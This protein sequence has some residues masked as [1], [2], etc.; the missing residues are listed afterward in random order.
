MNRL[1]G[2]MLLAA[3]ALVGGG[4]L[5]FERI[6]ASPIVA[7]IAVGEMPVALGVDARTGHVFVANKY[8]ASVSILDGMHGKLI[9]TV[10]VGPSPQAIAI[11]A[12]VGHVFVAGSTSTSMLDAASG[13]VLYTHKGGGFPTN[14]LVDELHHRL[15]VTAG[16]GPSLAVFDTRTGAFVRSLQLL[17][18]AGVMAM[19]AQ[20]GHLFV[21][22]VGTVATLDAVSGRVLSRVV[23]GANPLA[24]AI[25]PQRHRLFAAVDPG[26]AATPGNQVCMIDTWSGQLLRTTPV[27]G[28]AALA[29]DTRTGRVFVASYSTHDHRAVVTLLDATSGARVGTAMVGDLPEAVT[30]AEKT[31]RVFVANSAGSTVTVLDAA[32]GSVIQTISMHGMPY[33]MAIDTTLGRV[34]VANDKLAHQSALDNIKQ[35]LSGVFHSTSAA[36]RDAGSVVVLNATG[37]P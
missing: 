13:V 12:Q 4:I 7:T 36:A 23:V 35:V 2:P 1:C 15:F 27:L 10:S 6:S 30:V 5:A 8:S 26:G 28:P 29:V 14:I 17:R 33:A 25:D 20:T 3:I 37:S 34:F 19:D 16:N 11:D 18:G 9:R 21:A 22:E 24:L 32:T 31:G